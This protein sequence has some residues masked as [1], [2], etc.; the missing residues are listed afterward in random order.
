MREKPN[1]LKIGGRE[2]ASRLIL[3]TGKFSS[4]QQ[5]KAALEASGAQMVTVA[6]RRADQFTEQT[7]LMTEKIRCTFGNRFMFE[8]RTTFNP[9]RRFAAAPDRADLEHLAVQVRYGG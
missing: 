1:R 9:K 3:G 8:K 7:A 5:M 4:P 6:L 2:F